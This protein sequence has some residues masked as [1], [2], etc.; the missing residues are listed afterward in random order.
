MKHDYSTRSSKVFAAGCTIA[1]PFLLCRVTAV[2]ARRLQKARIQFA[3]SINQSL[4]LISD[5]PHGHMDAAN[6]P[7]PLQEQEIP[8]LEMEAAAITL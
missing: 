3:E 1:N 4:R 2:Y 6:L 5:L 8:A 7:Q